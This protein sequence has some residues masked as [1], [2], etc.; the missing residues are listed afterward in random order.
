MNQYYSVS[1]Y[2]RDAVVPS[3]KF[4]VDRDALIRHF[5]T[6]S[7]SRDYDLIFSVPGPDISFEDAVFVPVGTHSLEAARSGNDSPAGAAENLRTFP[8]TKRDGEPARS[9]SEK[10]LKDLGA[11][12]CAWGGRPIRSGESLH[13]DHLLPF[14]Q[15]DRLR[16]LLPA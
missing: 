10:L 6:W 14:L 4:P 1:G 12:A 11:L 7:L 3:G 13:I 8:V 5:G 2:N 16:D 15:N 9:F